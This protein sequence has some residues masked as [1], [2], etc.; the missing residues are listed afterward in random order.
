MLTG[1]TLGRL[2]EIHRADRAY[3]HEDALPGAPNHAVWM[4]DFDPAH[5]NLTLAAL[6]AL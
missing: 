2:A 3:I 4:I 5:T 6:Q 1:A